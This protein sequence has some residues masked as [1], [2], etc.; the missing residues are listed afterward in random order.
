MLEFKFINNKLVQVI[1]KNNKELY[2]KNFN[3]IF[4]NIK[5]ILN[6]DKTWLIYKNGDNLSMMLYRLFSMYGKVYTMNNKYIDYV[7]KDINNQEKL[8]D[9]IN[10]LIVGKKLTG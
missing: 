5:G 1:K 8:I 7:I 4:N 9:E 6:K 2:V 3:V 10:A